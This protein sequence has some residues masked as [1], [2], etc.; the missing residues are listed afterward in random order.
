[1]ARGLNKT[2][3]YMINE[4]YFAKSSRVLQDECFQ[5]HLDFLNAQ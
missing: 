2:H 5:F 3:D 4:T 1:M